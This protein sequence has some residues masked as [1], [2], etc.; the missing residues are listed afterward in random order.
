MPAWADFCVTQIALPTYSSPSTRLG[1]ISPYPGRPE[2]QLIRVGR[3]AADP[4]GPSSSIQL[5]RAPPSDI[6]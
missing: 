2:V 6:S 5:G 1:R 4:A 3:R